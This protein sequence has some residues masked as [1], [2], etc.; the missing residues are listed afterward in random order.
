MKEKINLGFVFF[1]ALLIVYLSLTPSPPVRDGDMEELLPVLE[2]GLITLSSIGHFVLYFLFAGALLTY[3][4]DTPKGHLE[5]FSIAFL[6]GIVMEFSQMHV[7][8]RVFSLQDILVNMLG[9]CLIFLDHR[10]G[11][12]EDVINLEDSLIQKYV[13]S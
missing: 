1:V 6:F 4:H 2:S 3:F 10:I 5:A 13:A 11:F 7:P 12:I 8:G 9:A